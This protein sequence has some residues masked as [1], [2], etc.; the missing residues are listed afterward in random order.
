MVTSRPT[1]DSQSPAA[2]TTTIAAPVVSEARNVMMATT[3]PSERP[4][5]EFLG[6]IAATAGKASAGGAAASRSSQGSAMPSIGSVVDMQASVVED[7]PARVVLVHQRNIVRGNNDRGA[8]F[9]EL[10]EQSQQPLSEIGIDVSGRL[11]GEQKLRARNDRSR[12]GRPLFFTSRENG[13]QR[14]HSFA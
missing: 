7:Q 8:R 10:D 11:V 3:A 2:L 9:V 12:D 6:T 4:A 5:S 13:R 1:S 14:R